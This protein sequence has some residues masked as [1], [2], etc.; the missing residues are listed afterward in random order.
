MNAAASG[1]DVLSCLLGACYAAISVCLPRQTEINADVCGCDRRHS[2][3]QVTKLV[4][5]YRSHRDLLTVP[6]RLFYDS[7]LVP[8]AD[9]E[10][11]NK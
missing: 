2:S 9:P 5:N 8:C 3:P 11:A 6:S 10:T 4:N 1:T 7:E